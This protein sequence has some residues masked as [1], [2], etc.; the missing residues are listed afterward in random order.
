ME[1]NAVYWGLVGQYSQFLGLSS[2]QYRVQ[3]YAFITN[4]QRLLCTLVSKMTHWL[5]KTTL[6]NCHWAFFCLPFFFFKRQVT[7]FWQPPS[8]L[9]VAEECERWNASA[10]WSLNKVGG[11]PLGAVNPAARQTL[12]G[13]FGL[14]GCGF[15]L[16]GPDSTH[17]FILFAFSLLP[18]PPF[19]SS[20]GK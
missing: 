7:Q 6:P 13:S 16:R 15:G 2:E 12:Y 1:S 4:K 14:P 17:G 20:V 8:L 10:Q 19:P 18:W 11:F 3:G 5:E 9:V